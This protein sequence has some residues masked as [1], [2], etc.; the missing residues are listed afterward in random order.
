[1]AGSAHVAQINTSPGGVPKLPVDGPVEIGPRGVV[2]DAQA[3]T[4]HHGSRD[5]ALCLY[6]TEVIGQLRAEGHPIEPGFAGEN[7]T[8]SGLDWASLQSG[9]RLRIGAD[10]VA[11]LTWPASPCAKNAAWFLERNYR[12]MDYGLHPGF[13]RWYAKV[14]S[15]GTVSPGAAVVVGRPGGS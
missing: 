11:E 13:S 2:G 1:M 3:D 7:L 15:G 8:I 6:S 14:I 4:K 9:D 10:V 5:Q 12:R